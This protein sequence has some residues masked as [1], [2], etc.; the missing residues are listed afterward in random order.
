MRR[1]KHNLHLPPCVYHRHGAYYHVKH[2]KWTRLGT[3]LVKALSEYARL[4][5]MPKGGMVQLIEDALPIITKGKAESTVKQYT[6]VARKLQEILAEFAPEQVTPRHVAQ[7]RRS[8]ADT[9]AVANR[10]LTVLRMVFDYALEEQIIE[11]NPCVGVK[12][13][14]Q[15]ARTRRILPK[16]YQAIKAKAKPLLAAVMDLCYLTGQRIGDVLKIKRADLQEGGI[17]VQQQKTGAR[18]LVAWTPELRAAVEVAKSLHGPVASMH[19]FKGTQRQAPT[20]HMIWKQWVK[21]CAAAGV[22]D[23]NIHDLRAMSGTE[24]EAQGHNPQA[25]LGHTDAKMTKRYLRDRVVPVVDGPSFGQ[26]KKAGTR[27]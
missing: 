16:E 2:G 3:D 9:Y 13:F 18:L 11:F 20:Y 17:F 7:I 15:H 14:E 22:E 23:A 6:Q 27:T 12:R 26:S 5:D 24:A 21:A 19:L 25:L 10:T 8:M 4:H 1:R